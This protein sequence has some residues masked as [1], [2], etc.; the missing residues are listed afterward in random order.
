MLLTWVQLAWVLMAWMPPV[1]CIGCSDK[2]VA[3]MS[4]LGLKDPGIAASGM[5]ANF[6][7]CVANFMPSSVTTYTTVERSLSKHGKTKTTSVLR[8]H[9]KHLHSHWNNV[10]ENSQMITQKLIT[11]QSQSA[12]KIEMPRKRIFGFDI[13]IYAETVLLMCKK[14]HNL[15]LSKEDVSRWLLAVIAIP[16]LNAND[17]FSFKWDQLLMKKDWWPSIKQHLQRSWV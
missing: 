15:W 4:A 7:C 11:L 3:G 1:A 2:K 12:P 8:R 16:F 10:R 9:L 13:L 14:S 5:G 17:D 6:F